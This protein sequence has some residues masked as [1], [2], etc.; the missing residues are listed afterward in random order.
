MF[1]ALLGHLRL[2]GLGEQFITFPLRPNV[3]ARSCNFC[4]GEQCPADGVHVTVR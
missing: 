1:A 4:G 2:G 3:Q